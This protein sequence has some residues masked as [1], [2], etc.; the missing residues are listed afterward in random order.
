MPIY[1]YE[2]EA[3]GHVFKDLR[4]FNDP[5]PDQCPEC[6]DT[7]VRR[8]ISGGNF[9]LKGGGW[10]DEGY[11]SSGASSGTKPAQSTE[12]TESTPS[13]ETSTDT[14]TSSD[15]SASSSDGTEAA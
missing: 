11:Q 3:C 7:Q 10:F 5:N 8:L 6:E 2:C 12:S 1:K 15:G 4:G 9:V 14:S 13:T